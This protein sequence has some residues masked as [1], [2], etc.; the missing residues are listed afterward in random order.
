MQ[1]I[2]WSKYYN[3]GKQKVGK[4][5]VQTR[6]QTKSSGISLPEVHGIGKGLDPNILPEKQVIKPIMTSEAKGMPQ[7][8]PRIGQGRAV[9]RWKIK[10]LK[11]PPVYKSIVKLSEKPIEQPKVTLKIPILES[12][13]IHNKIIPIPDYTILQTRSGDDSSSRMVKRKTIQDICREIPRY[14]NPIY[15]PPIK[16][17]KIPIQ[18]VY[19]NLLDFDQEINMDFE[20]NSPFQEGV[21]SKMYQRPDNS[22]LQEPQELDSLINTGKLLQKFLLKQADIDKKN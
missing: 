14:P 8:K 4:Y 7:I 6:S 2:L 17:T 10:T 5:L 1:S 15:R 3:M 12:L 13:Q 9:L 21:I 18:E 19:R 11:S 16:P 22:Y 20:E